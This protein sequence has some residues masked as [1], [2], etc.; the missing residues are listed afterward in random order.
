MGPTIPAG[1]IVG[2]DA[3]AIN[4]SPELWEDPDKFDMDRFR[5]LREKSDNDNRFHF[6]TTGSDSPGW[7]DGTQACPGRF[8]ATSTLKIALAHV[9]LNYDVR[10]PEGTL[11]LDITPLANGTF[12]PDD[13]ATIMF[14][15]RT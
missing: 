2:I 7:G 3:Q 10:L 12:K 13:K 4:R 9:L 14:K 15:S 5:R 1:T 6:L 8:F 11:P